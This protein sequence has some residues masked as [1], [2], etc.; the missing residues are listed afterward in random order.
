MFKNNTIVYQVLNKVKQKLNHATSYN[1]LTEAV[2]IAKSA[3]RKLVYNNFIFVIIC[4]I[5]FVL[6]LI[7]WSDSNNNTGFQWVS[8]DGIIVASLI[9]IGSLSLLII[10]G[11]NSSVT[12][13]S[14]DIYQMWG[15]LDNNIQ[16]SPIENGPVSSMLVHFEQFKRGNYSRKIIKEYQSTPNV[17]H[18]FYFYKFEF[19]DT[20]LTYRNKTV[21]TKKVYYYRYG[22]IF[23]FKYHKNIYIISDGNIPHP[24]NYSVSSSNFNQKFS[25]GGI[26]EHQVAK[27]L[28][29]IV[30]EAIMKASDQ[31]D[32][33]NIEI[34]DSGMLCISYSHS[35]LLYQFPKYDLNSADQ[36][37]AELNQTEPKFPSISEAIRLYTL[38][39]KYSDNNFTTPSN[40]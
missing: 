24:L 13:L 23:D 1:D 31:L 32:N 28:K 14:H 27:F 3:G 25:L 38:I 22:L 35:G 15:F 37:L 16:Y 30:V 33:L 2:F 17:K 10:F 40:L 19:V 12:M 29:P 7:H 39:L 8:Q 20:E 11:R 34:N 36:F 18:P 6:A 5:T 21:K 9:A 4:T 26:D